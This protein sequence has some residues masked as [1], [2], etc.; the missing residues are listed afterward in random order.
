MSDLTVTVHDTVADLKPNEWNAVVSQQSRTGCLFERHEWLAAYEAASDATPRYLQVRRDG[1]LVGAH[2]AF[3]RSLS[4]PGLRFLGPARPGTNGAMIATAED[5]VL[6]AL[7]DGVADLTSG[8][9]VGHL[10]KPGNGA[11]LR[12]A[13]RLRERGYVPTVRDC[14]F[15][16]GLDRPWEDVVGDFSGKKRRNLRKAE[17]AGVEGTTAHVTADAVD[18]FADRHDE[19]MCRIGGAGVS[20]AFLQA[21]RAHLG[22]RVVLF[23]STLDDAVAGEIFAVCDRERSTLH[24]LFPAYDPGRFDQ[25]ATEAVYRTALRWGIDNGYRNCDLGETTPH[26]ADGT[27]AFKSELGAEPVPTLRW[28]R[29]DSLVGRAVYRFGGS[30]LPDLP[31]RTRNALG[32]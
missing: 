15:R 25:Y 31:A 6:D 28:E 1:T 17:E 5:D 23:Q 10:L 24:L 19:H 20:R 2:P 9:T 16:I 30:R 32:R 4:M 27:Y 29:I 21:L 18:A 13:Q 11:S 12:Y 8:R 3:E 14:Q 7:L 26:F 22:D